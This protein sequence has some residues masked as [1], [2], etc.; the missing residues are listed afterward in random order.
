MGQL[1]Y[2]G[3]RLVAGTLYPAY[4]SFK[5]VKSKNVKVSWLQCGWAHRSPPHDLQA[6]NAD[7]YMCNR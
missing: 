5:A 3:V 2:M 1:I 7:R 6:P 4:R